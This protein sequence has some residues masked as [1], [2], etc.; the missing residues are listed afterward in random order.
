VGVIGIGAA[1]V[2]YRRA[3]RAVAECTALVNGSVGSRGTV[4]RGRCAT[5]RSSATTR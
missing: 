5:S 4:D 2:A 1:I 3:A